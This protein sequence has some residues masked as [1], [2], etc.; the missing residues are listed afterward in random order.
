MNKSYN[1]KQL[2][3]YL[4]GLCY[5]CWMAIQS[6]PYMFANRPLLH[7]VNCTGLDFVDLESMRWTNIF[8]NFATPMP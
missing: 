8:L 6:F 3:D 1:S 7:C 5:N 4:G 2:P